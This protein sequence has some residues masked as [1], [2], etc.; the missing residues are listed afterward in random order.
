MYPEIDSCDAKTRPT[1]LLRKIAEGHAYTITLRG[2]AIV[3]LVPNARAERADAAAGVEAMRALPKVRVP[4]GETLKDWI[5][6]G[7]R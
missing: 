3:D 4:N 1:E 7:H 5:A 2:R 6:E